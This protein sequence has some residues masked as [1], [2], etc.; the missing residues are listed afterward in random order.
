MKLIAVLP[1]LPQTVCPACSI[2]T[3][4][5]THLDVYKRQFL[6]IDPV[7]LVHKFFLH[8]RDDH[9]AAAEGKGAE[10]EVGNKQ[11]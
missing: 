8:Q 10:V 7:V 11:F 5:Y 3:V 2:R 1:Q 6:I 9:I 4:S